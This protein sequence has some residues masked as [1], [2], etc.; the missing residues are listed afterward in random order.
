MTFFVATGSGTGPSDET[1]LIT[2]TAGS[3]AL[4]GHIAVHLPQRLHLS[5]RHLII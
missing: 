3:I 1:D 2:F 5:S 4:T